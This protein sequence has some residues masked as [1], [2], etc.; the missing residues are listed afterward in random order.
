MTSHLDM[1]PANIYLEYH[2]KGYMLV[3]SQHI[4]WQYV[5]FLF[6]RRMFLFLQMVILWLVKA[7]VQ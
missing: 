2:W 1:L 5:G 6:W 7:T 3:E 4:Y